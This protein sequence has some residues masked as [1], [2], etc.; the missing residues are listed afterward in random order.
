MRLDKL[1]VVRELKKPHFLF[2]ALFLVGISG[3]AAWLTGANLLFEYHFYKARAALSE[4]RLDEARYHAGHC[5]NLSPQ[6][7]RT[8][9]LAAQVAR[10]FGDVKAAER[11]LTE[12]QKLL[13]L[14]D[15]VALERSLLLAQRGEVDGVQSQLRP[16]IDRGHPQTVQILEAL[17]KGYLRVFR[18]EE[19]EKCLKE[20]LEH[21][22]K[23]AEANLLLGWSMQQKGMAAESINYFRRSVELDPDNAVPHFQLAMALIDNVQPDEAI[24]DLRYLAKVQ[25]NNPT[26]LVSLAR[27]EHALGEIEEARATLDEVLSNYPNNPGA[28]IERGVLANNTES[29]ATAEVYLKKALEIDPSNPQGNFNY[30]LCLIKQGKEKEAAEQQAKIRRIDQD[31]HDSADL[32]TS[33]IPAM[34]DNPVVHYQAGVILLRLGNDREAER[35]LFRALKL[36]PGYVPAQN[37][38]LEHFKKK[39]DFKQAASLKEAIETGRPIT[40]AYPFN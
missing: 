14:S 6:S 26:V 20:W 7:G 36:D 33:R 11:Q 35:M 1:L 17:A 40:A 30:H 23:S 24:D 27:C 19:A 39:G 29:P 37:V 32:L 22:P 34:P 16:L 12:A 38:L 21:D 28:L 25:P 3:L 9:L 13:H 31:L 8:H 15:D 2:A 5:L 10:R 18:L 4:N